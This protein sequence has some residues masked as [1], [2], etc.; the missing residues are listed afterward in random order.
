MVTRD[1]KFDAFFLIGN[2]LGYNIG[3]ADKGVQCPE[4]TILFYENL[5]REMK[6]GSK[7]VSFLNQIISP[8]TAIQLNVFQDR[9]KSQ[10]S[11]IKHFVIAVNTHL[12]FHSCA[13]NVRLIQIKIAHDMMVAAEQDLL[14]NYGPHCKIL[15]LVAGD[16]NSMPQ[17]GILKFL[18]GQAIPPNSIDWYSGGRDQFIA[19]INLQPE[20]KLKSA[21]DFDKVKYT[22]LVN[23]FCEVIDHILYDENL[24][25]LNQWIENPSHAEVTENIG[26]PSQVFPSDHIAQIA[27]FTW[28]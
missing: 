26:L 2:Q 23:N 24:V 27:D 1:T 22:T 14:K 11:G 28:R 9:K 8:G 7:G 6:D 21:I 25:S 3:G 13:S 16:L 5:L 10:A 18:Q 15:K 4:N 20:F 12:Y 19:N 17:S